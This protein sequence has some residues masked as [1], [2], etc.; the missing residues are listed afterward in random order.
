MLPND[1]EAGQRLSVSG[2]L[3]QVGTR[4][5]L[6]VTRISVGLTDLDRLAILADRSGTDMPDQMYQL[7][8]EYAVIADFYGDEHLAANIGPHATGRIRAAA[9]SAWK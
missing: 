9:S 4:Y 6:N 5:F 1:I 2:V 8:D 7:A 3:R